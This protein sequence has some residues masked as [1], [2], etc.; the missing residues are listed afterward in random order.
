MR[1][2]LFAGSF[3]PPT[4]GHHDAVLQ[5]RAECDHLVVAVLRNEEKSPTFSSAERASMLRRM[6]RGAGG[7]TVLESDDLLVDVVLR[8]NIAVLFRGIRDEKDRDYEERQ[9]GYHRRILPAP[10]FP[11]VRFLPARDDLRE[12]SSSLVK[13]FA[14]LNLDVSR[15][16][17][18]FVQ[19]RLALR[20]NSQ[21]FLGVTGQMATGKSYV[22]AQLAAGLEARGARAHYVNLDELIRD[23]YAERTP[24]AQAVRDELAR[25]F[26]DRVLTPGRDG[27]DRAVLKVEVARADA[28]VRRGLH[29]LTTPHV[30]RLIRRA[31]RG[32][33]GLVI[34]EWAQLCE[35]RMDYLVC[36]NAVVVESPDHKDFLAARGAAEFFEAM[37]RAQWSA[38]RK[39]AYLQAASA[40]HG[41]GR[42]WR[43]ANRRGQGV[44]GLMGEVESWMRERFVNAHTRSAVE[45]EL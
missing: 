42:V 17:P 5:A 36:G 43:Y 20:L 45:D 41:C 13:S 26:G 8:E 22:A 37:A 15:M 4:F 11:A 30:E 24:G 32:R 9:L 2:G 14:S 33:Q 12:V 38:D 6:L 40:Q 1:R 29:E 44:D 25:V 10:R 18:R 16:V 7:V 39:V 34:V 27:V 28:D 31:V 21:L 23:L 35:T 3:D 19:A